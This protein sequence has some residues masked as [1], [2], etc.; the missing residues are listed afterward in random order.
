MKAL[1]NEAEFPDAVTA[2]ADAEDERSFATPV[3]RDRAMQDAVAVVNVERQSAVLRQRQVGGAGD[4]D[5]LDVLR[6]TREVKA[7]MVAVVVNAAVV[8][9]GLVIE[10]HVAIAA[11]FAIGGEAPDGGVQ[12]GIAVNADGDIGR[13]KRRVGTGDEGLFHGRA[14]YIQVERSGV[15]I[16]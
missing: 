5:V 16:F 8:A 13:G 10:D 2:V 4:S 9:R 11:H 7:V 6:L 1:G 12:G 15:C 3:Q 14:V